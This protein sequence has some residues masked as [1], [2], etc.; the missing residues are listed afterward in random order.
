MVIQGIF[1]HR[2]LLLFEICSRRDEK[3]IIFRYMVIKSM[4]EAQSTNVCLFKDCK[5]ISVGPL[6]FKYL[7]MMQVNEPAPMIP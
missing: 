2:P 6:Q 5:P 7:Y 3:V 1:P 4:A